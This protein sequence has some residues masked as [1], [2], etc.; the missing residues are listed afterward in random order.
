MSE[1]SESLQLAVVAARAAA[2]KQ[3]SDIIVLNVG[4][5]LSITEFFVVASASNIRQVRAI[6]DEVKL[7]ANLECDR[8]PG[9][10]E[11]L[12]EG[13]W[14]LLDFGD[15]VVHIFSEE[16]RR[17]YEIERLYSDVPKVKWQ[18]E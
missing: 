15:V 10:A 3:G 12:R 16:T 18:A 7:M 14:V 8:S 11:G 2:E 9:R 6:A 1:Q 4:D 17:F 5:V 13:Q